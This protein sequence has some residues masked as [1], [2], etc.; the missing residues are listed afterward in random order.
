MGDYITI[1]EAVAK[2]SKAAQCTFTQV[3]GKKIMFHGRLSDGKTIIMCTPQAKRQQGGFCWT[4][5]TKVQYDLLNSYDHANVVFR[6]E[7][8][9]LVMFDWSWLKYCLTED[10]METPSSN[11]VVFFNPLK[12]SFI[13]FPLSI[14]QEPFSI[15]ATVR[16]CRLCAT[17]S[18]SKD[19]IAVK[20]PAL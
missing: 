11:T 10:C 2:A 4:D 8:N 9:R 15:T 12:I 14:A 6:L 5:I 1:N 18:L 13:C 17:R 3:P 7:G 19:S 16:F 20:I